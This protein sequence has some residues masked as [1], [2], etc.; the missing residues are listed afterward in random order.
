M[1]ADDDPVL[2]DEE[3]LRGQRYWRELVEEILASTGQTGQWP[4]W[5]P[6]FYGDGVTPMERE[7]QSICD[8]RSW[9]LDRSFAI[10]QILLTDAQPTISAEVKD[11]AASLLDFRE[12]NDDADVNRWFEEVPPHERVPRSTLIIRLEFSEATAAAARSLLIKWLTPDTTVAEMEAFI[13][14]SPGVEHW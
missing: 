10:S 12:I 5:E 7:Y 9:R 3:W 1:A 11:Y 8:G 14:E 2:D 6:K 4:S 13:E